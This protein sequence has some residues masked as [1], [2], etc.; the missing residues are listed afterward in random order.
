MGC[1]AETGR[2]GEAETG[3]AG[4]KNADKAGRAEVS[5]AEAGRNLVREL[6]SA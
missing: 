3:Q 1:G 2:D 5:R 6:D 4:R